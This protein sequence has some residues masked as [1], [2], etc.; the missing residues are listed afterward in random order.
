MAAGFPCLKVERTVGASIVLLDD[1]PWIYAQ[2]TL[3]VLLVRDIGVYLC[4]LHQVTRRNEYVRQLVDEEVFDLVILNGSV[5]VWRVHRICEALLKYP[6]E[7][8]I[9]LSGG[10]VLGEHIGA[11][12][13]DYVGIDHM[14]PHLVE[15][16]HAWV[17]YGCEPGRQ[18]FIE[19]SLRDGLEVVHV[20]GGRHQDDLGPHSLK[21]LLHRVKQVSEE[22]LMRDETGCALVLEVEVPG[23][24]LGVA[25]VNEGPE[26]EQGVGAFFAGDRQEVKQAL[27]L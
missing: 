11:Y 5:G 12:V 26:Q 1:R 25:H 14:H 18:A 27:V 20:L 4:K 24:D 13:L 22:L 3:D 23:C 15:L 9:D 6:L 10:H 21:L 2:A 17:R 16:E 8:Q 7:C 19:R